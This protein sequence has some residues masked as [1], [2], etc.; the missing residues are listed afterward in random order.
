MEGGKG[1][2]GLDMLVNQYKKKK[3]DEKS[4]N[5][6]VWY[7][8]RLEDFKKDIINRL[9]TFEPYGNRVDPIDH[10]LYNLW[11][12]YNWSDLTVEQLY[13]KKK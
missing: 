11:I 10:T 6:V 5:E 7:N 2:M 1:F 12:M 4:E 13:D 8:E 9:K 3:N